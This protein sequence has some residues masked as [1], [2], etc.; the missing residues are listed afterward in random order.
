MQE[1]EYATIKKNECA[2]IKKNETLDLSWLSKKIGE[3]P[4]INT[5]STEEHKESSQFNATKKQYWLKQCCDQTTIKSN[6]TISL[7]EYDYDSSNFNTKETY[8]DQDANLNGRIYINRMESKFNLLTLTS[9]V[10]AQWIIDNINNKKKYLMYLVILN[11]NVDMYN[12][13]NSLHVGILIFDLC[14]L[15]VYWFDPNKHKDVMQ[16]NDD[17]N[18]HQHA[19]DELFLYYVDSINY[20]LQTIHNNQDYCEHGLTVFEFMS[21][22]WMKGTGCCLQLHWCS[23]LTDRGKC[24]TICLLF[25][26]ILNNSDY[27]PSE[28][29]QLLVELEGPIRKKIYYSYCQTIIAKF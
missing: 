26:Q 29:F 23:D 2:T 17:I 19:L 21:R 4:L 12:I 28:L 18:Y 16:I 3:I 1:N 20:H 14:F 9:S 7:F 15:R 24:L 27:S 6:N 22:N 13:N 25:A 10:M 8:K 5:L 11:P